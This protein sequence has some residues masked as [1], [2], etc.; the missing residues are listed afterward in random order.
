MNK[1]VRRSGKKEKRNAGTQRP[2]A[3]IHALPESV[4]RL[5]A[6]FCDEQDVFSLYQTCQWFKSLVKDGSLKKYFR[7]RDYE[8]L[9]KHFRQ[10]MTEHS[11]GGKIAAGCLNGCVLS[12]M[13]VSAYRDSESRWKGI[14]F[15][16][17]RQMGSSTMLCIFLKLHDDARVFKTIHV[18]TTCR[19]TQRRF[20]TELLACLYKVQ[21]TICPK[22]CKCCPM[23]VR[24]PRN[25]DEPA[26]VTLP[27]GLQ[28]Q[29]FAANPLPA[30]T[31]SNKSR[32]ARKVKQIASCDILLINDPNL[33]PRIFLTLA[34]T[35][36]VIM[37]GTAD[38]MRHMVLMSQEGQEEMKFPVIHR[39]IWRYADDRTDDEIDVYR[40]DHPEVFDVLT[41]KTN[42]QIL[43]ER[44]S[45]HG[46]A[47]VGAEI[48]A[49][50]NRLAMNFGY[51]KFLAAG[52]LL[53][54]D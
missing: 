45:E 12:H 16:S 15:L 49:S 48:D 2:A 42:R 46:Q 30:T 40:A 26:Q 19:V 44:I 27:N 28:V 43:D 29:V 1:R 3:P 17:A 25:W 37:A 53:D 20:I 5:T 47:A 32:N 41:Q 11:W 24:I 9:V 36:R 8:Q 38:Y 35:T 31:R 18:L 22:T 7:Q 33:I 39:D 50:R 23:K 21:G 14:E 10:H 6:T 34:S 13:L 4:T 52:G 51:D 54:P